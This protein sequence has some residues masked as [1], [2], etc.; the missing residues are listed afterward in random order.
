MNFLQNLTITI[1]ILTLSL[2]SITENIM[3]ILN[4]GN[5]HLPRLGIAGCILSAFVLFGMTLNIMKTG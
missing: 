4:I 3:I 2:F 1:S 5:E